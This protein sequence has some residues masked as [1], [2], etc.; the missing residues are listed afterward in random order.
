MNKSNQILN[1]AIEEFNKKNISSAKNLTD[2]A[3]SLNPNKFDALN[4]M[5]VI[6]GYENNHAQ[7]IQY[8][9]MCL[10]IKPN[11]LGSIFNLANAFFNLKIRGLTWILWKQK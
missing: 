5:G 3:I 11:H 1:K 2:Q 8:F 7:A 4:S 9:N 6:L 10:K